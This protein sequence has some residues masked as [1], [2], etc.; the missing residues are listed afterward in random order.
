M[1]GRRANG[2]VLTFGVSGMLRQSNLVMWDSETESWW[3][4]GTFNAIVGEMAGTG[5]EVVPSAVVSW[6]DFKAAHPDGRVLSRRSF[7]EYE[8]QG[9]YGLNPYLGY[10]TDAS[11]FLFEGPVDTRLPAMERVVGVQIGGRTVAYPYQ[12]LAQ[13]GV[14]YDTLGDREIV[15]LY[16]GD[17]RSPVDAGQVSAGREVGT[18]S[19]FSPMVDGRKLTLT[20]RKD[21]LFEDRETGTVWDIFG[22]ALEGGLKGRRLIPVISSPSFWF[23]WAAAH[24]D[25]G[26]LGFENR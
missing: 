24:P 1:F 15:V 26:V 16:K 18:A 20:A 22:F 13:R 11:P 10:D 19:V 2:K 4:Q 6:Q 3:Q 14:V 9:L 25:T 21:G 5:L 7:P 8:G 12:A 17:T 23:Y